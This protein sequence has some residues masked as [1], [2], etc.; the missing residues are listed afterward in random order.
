[1]GEEE[2]DGPDGKRAEDLRTER[3]R[4]QPAQEDCAEENRQVAKHQEEKR[5]ARIHFNTH[6]SGLSLSEAIDDVANAFHFYL[7]LASWS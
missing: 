4:D 6:P 1:M 3:S 5:G 2:S 7:S